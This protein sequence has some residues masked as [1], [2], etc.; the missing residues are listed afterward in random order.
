MTIKVV[1]DHRDVCLSPAP[2]IYK[3]L[4]DVDKPQDDPHQE[5]SKSHRCFTVLGQSHA[6]C[7][8]DSHRC[9]C[10]LSGISDFNFIFPQGHTAASSRVKFR[11]ARPRPCWPLGRENPCDSSDSARLKSGLIVK[12]KVRASWRTTFARDEPGSCAPGQICLAPSEQTS[13]V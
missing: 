12:S 13:A 8:R 2:R 4:T 11:S 5:Q 9:K 6:G 7:N 1:C 3:R 10:Y